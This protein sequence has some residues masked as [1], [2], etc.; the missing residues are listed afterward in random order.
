MNSKLTRYITGTLNLGFVN[1][2]DEGLVV[3]MALCLITTITGNDILTIELPY[4]KMQLNVLVYLSIILSSVQLSL[5]TV[6]KVA[7]KG[8]LADLFW[9]SMQMVYMNAGFIIL[10]LKRS[11]PVLVEQ[12]KYL[13]FAWAV[14]MCRL[15][16]E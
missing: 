4:I 8:R 12:P 10:V 13:F 9:D 15:T 3:L 2:V 14:I 16:V 7:T 5:G 1:P 6:A 11:L